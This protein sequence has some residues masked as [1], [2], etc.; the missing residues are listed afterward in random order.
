MLIARS[1]HNNIGE[2]KYIES[3]EMSISVDKET[4]VELTLCSKMSVSGCL[5]AANFPIKVNVCRLCE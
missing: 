2:L 3:G 4:L 5:S 1:D